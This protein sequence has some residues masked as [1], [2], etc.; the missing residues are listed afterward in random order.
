M[1]NSLFYSMFSKKIKIGF[2][3]SF[4][5]LFVGSLYYYQYGNKNTNHQRSSKIR[6]LLIYNWTH[7]L[8]QEI[9]DWFTQETGIPVI[10]DSYENQETLEAKLLTYCGYDIVFPPAWPVFARALSNKLV[11]KMDRNKIPNAKGI[12]SWFYQQL[13]KIDPKGEYAMPYMWGTTGIGV[14]K[15][16]L[17]D[18]LG[19]E[20]EVGWYLF[21]DPKISKILKKHHLRLSLMDS[22]VDVFQGILIYLG[23]NP[24]T[25]DKNLWNKAI[26]CLA[27]SMDVIDIFESN[28]Q[29]EDFMDSNSQVIQ[30]CSSY[31]NM[32]KVGSS[33][34]NLSYE[35]PRE[36]AMMWIDVMMIPKD[37]PNPDLAHIFINFILR[38]DVIARCSQL[39]RCFNAIPASKQYMNEEEQQS[40]Q[41]DSKIMKRLYSDEVLRSDLVRYISHSF[42]KIKMGIFSSKNA[43]K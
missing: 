34:P 21:F 8:P 31:G 29:Y 1:N 28:R 19:Y 20:P 17:R 40:L 39:V 35:V 14:D 38:P 16:A 2:C 7:Y 18:A 23:Y 25:E 33:N 3:I 30:I 37:S 13:S 12:D 43:E 22:G 5:F 36:G 42:L 4:F 26:V 6:T 10:C 9:I 11:Y 27:N 41:P 15:K 24:V 32:A